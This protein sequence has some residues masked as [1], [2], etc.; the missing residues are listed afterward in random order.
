MAYDPADLP[1]VDPT[2][3]SA[4]SFL[5][6]RAKR[7]LPQV[8]NWESPDTIILHDFCL[9]PYPCPQVDAP[10]AQSV[11]V[12]LAS[13]AQMDV[14]AEGQALLDRLLARM[15]PQC[16][17]WGV[18]NAP[19]SDELWW[20][21]Y[22]YRRD[23]TP[24]A[25]CLDYVRDIFQPLVIDAR[26]PPDLAWTFFSLEVRKEHLLGRA[27]IAV[28]MYQ[29]GLD[30]SWKV[31]GAELELGNHYQHFLVDG[32]MPEFLMA[33]RTSVH[34]PR[35]PK[36]LA[37]LVPPQLIYG[38]WRVWLA[39]KQRADTIYF[40]RIGP[41]QAVWMMRKHGWPQPMCDSM[42]TLAPALQHVRFDLGIDFCRAATP[43]VPG[44]PP[45]G[46]GKTGV[47]ATF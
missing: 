45:I 27:P 36:T 33:L 41:M 38:A 32:E 40:Q 17:V 29:E 39:R 7:P 5:A 43:P 30:L 25:L 14:L 16:T 9:M 46:F 22:F 18:K 15:G 35:H 24:D 12:L 8:R 42:E 21:F 3:H 37:R 6:L 20:E 34:A 44:E 11:E 31:R 28:T 1:I 19:D 10:R 13:F 26:P 4:P 47:Y 23:H 2:A